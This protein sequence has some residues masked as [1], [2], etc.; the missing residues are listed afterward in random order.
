MRIVS[1]AWIFGSIVEFEATSC[2]ETHA[3]LQ[4]TSSSYPFDVFILEGF[5]KLPKKY[6][7]KLADQN[8]ILHNAYAATRP[9]LKHYAGLF[10]VIGEDVD[11]RQEVYC[12]LRLIVIEHILA[13]EAFIHIDLDLFFQIPFSRMLSHFLPASP[14]LSGALA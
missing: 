11:V 1:T 3:K 8:I 5:E 6:I 4:M 14:E 9:I 12:F 10:E 7:R 2:L 13:G